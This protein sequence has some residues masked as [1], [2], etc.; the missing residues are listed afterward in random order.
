MDYHSATKKEQTADT[1]KNIDELKKLG[2]NEIWVICHLCKISE[3]TKLMCGR[4][5]QEQCSVCGKGQEW[6]FWNDWN[7]LHLHRCELSICQ[8]SLQCYHSALFYM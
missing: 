8:N 7:I 1:Y 3:Q 4:K 2:C 6:T 5:K